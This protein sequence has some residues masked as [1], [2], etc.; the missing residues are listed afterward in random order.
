MSRPVNGCGESLLSLSAHGKRLGTSTQRNT[1]LTMR[2]RRCLHPS[3]LWQG[4]VALGA[5]TTIRPSTPGF[6]AGLRSKHQAGVANRVWCDCAQRVAASYLLHSSACVLH[7]KLQGGGGVDS[8]ITSTRCYR[9]GYLSPLKAVMFTCAESPLHVVVNAREL[10]LRQ[11]LPPRLP[12][13]LPSHLAAAEVFV[14]LSDLCLRV[15]AA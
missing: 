13:R 1:P 15:P 10:F 9:V 5:T 12:P 3:C 14:R 4:A 2:E 6:H 8:S 11:R 7:S